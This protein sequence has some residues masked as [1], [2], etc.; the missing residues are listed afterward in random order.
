MKRLF[1]LCCIAAAVFTSCKKD[2][3]NHYK[4]LKGPELEF[5]H[6]KAWTSVQLGHDGKPLT[7]S[8]VVNKEAMESL[9]S[10][11]GG[12]Q[13]VNSVS[14]S[15]NSK[16][17]SLPFTHALLDW[18][19]EGHEPAPIYTVPHFDFHFYMQTEAGRLNIPAFETDSSK[20]V[21]FPAPDYFPATYFPVPGGV[22]KM[23]THWVDATTPE[24]NGQPFT[25]TFIYGSYDGRVT[26]LE[27]MITKAFIDANNVFERSIPQPA[28]FQLSG[29][30]PTK[31]TLSKNNGDLIISLR[32]FVYRQAN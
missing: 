4:E 24:L 3:D 15:F 2:K 10:S 18:N 23:G 8:I 27:P 29:Y 17:T 31:Y 32:D 13:H 22:E 6:G 14:L 19:P 26:F 11:G 28:K 7:A 9:V 20:F 5:Q 25:E 12:H 21:I 16:I 1:I 30:Y